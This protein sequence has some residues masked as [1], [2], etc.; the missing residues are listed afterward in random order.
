MVWLSLQAA[1]LLE[2]D[3]IHA[4]VLNIH[5]IKPLDA[6]AILESVKCTKAVVTAEEHMANGGLGDAVAQLLAENLPCPQEYVAIRDQFGQ[7]GTPSQLME[8]YGLTTQAV[9]ESAKRAMAR[10]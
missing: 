10:R 1:D 4:E 6:E 7:S 5:T 3:G 9:A 8:H 2:R